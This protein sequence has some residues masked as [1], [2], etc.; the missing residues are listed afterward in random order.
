MGQA[1]AGTRIKGGLAAGV[2]GG[3]S[4]G[5]R[6]A[7]THLEGVLQ[8]VFVA[9]GKLHHRVLGRLFRLQVCKVPEHGP[10]PVGPRAREHRTDGSET[11]RAR[12]LPRSAGAA[13]IFFIQA[14]FG[15]LLRGFGTYLRKAV[16]P[17]GELLFPDRMS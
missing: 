4:R 11:A 12:K 8:V 9:G 17:W 16:Y 1:T 5:I 15:L 13:M 3:H 6:H 14:S 10:G 7:P 2:A